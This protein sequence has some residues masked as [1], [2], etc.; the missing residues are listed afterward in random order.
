VATWV[1]AAAIGLGVVAI[2]GMSGKMLRKGARAVGLG[3]ADR[4]AG[5]FVGLVEGALAAAILVVGATWVM[6]D[7]SPLLQN[8]ESP[9]IL[10]QLQGY[11]ADHRD[12]L[13]DVAAPLLEKRS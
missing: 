10:E 6:G 13:P 12:Q 1:A 9:Q 8:A 7:D 11:L 4:V 2:V 3:W 5:G